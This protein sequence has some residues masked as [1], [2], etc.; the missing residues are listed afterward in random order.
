MQLPHRHMR[1]N[2]VIRLLTYFASLCEEGLCPVLRVICVTG[3]VQDGSLSLDTA[4]KVEWFHMSFCWIAHRFYALFAIR[5]VMSLRVS[6][7]K[8]SVPTGRICIKI[9]ICVFFENLVKKFKF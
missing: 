9:G 6:A 5:F 1:V 8:D 7:R 3:S 4:N 2:T